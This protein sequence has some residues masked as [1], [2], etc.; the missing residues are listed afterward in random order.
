MSILNIRSLA[1]LRAFAYVMLPVIST[2]LVTLGVYTSHEA[3]LWVGL[4]LA[5]LGPGVAFV[6]V[7]GLDTFRTAFYALLAAGQAILIGYGLVSAE[8]VGVWLPV[9]SAVIGL[10][11]GGVAAANTDTTKAVIDI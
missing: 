3:E 11:G 9:I 5:I 10:A 4:V 6:M 8:D 2:L 1:D 7:R